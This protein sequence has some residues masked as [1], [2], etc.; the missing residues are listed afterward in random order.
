[1]KKTYRVCGEKWK[2]SDKKHVTKNQKRPLSL[3][4]L[5]SEAGQAHVAAR[6]HAWWLMLEFLLPSSLSEDESA[7]VM[8]QRV[9]R[10]GVER[11]GGGRATSVQQRQRFKL[12]AFKADHGARWPPLHCFQSLGEGV[13]NLNVHVAGWVLGHKECAQLEASARLLFSDA[14]GQQ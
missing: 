9:L 5:L 3:P 13:A 10:S 12:D 2:R 11:F 6:K 8:R 7:N 14:K 4:A 1:M